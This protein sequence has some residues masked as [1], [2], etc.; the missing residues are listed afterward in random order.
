MLSIAA[1]AGSPCAT[2]ADGTRPTRKPIAKKGG[3]VGAL[4][5]KWDAGG[6]AAGNTGDYYDNRDGGHSRLNIAPYP[7]LQ[8]TNYGAAV[9]TRGWGAQRQ[10]LPHVTFGNSSTAS[11][12]TKGGSHTRRLYS[13]R[14]GLQLLHRQYV[15]NNVYVYPEHLDH[16]IGHNGCFRS[17]GF[18]DIFPTNTPYAIASQGSSGSDQPFVKAI[19][20]ALAAFRPEVKKRLVKAGLLMPTLQMIFRSTNKNLK[21]PG[22]YLTGRAHPTVFLGKNVDAL[23]MVKMA[24]AVRLNTIP[25]MMRL[26]VVEEDEPKHGRD[27]FDPGQTEKLADTPGVIARIVRGGAYRRRIVVSAEAT[28]D[29]NGR[30]LTYAWRVLR[31][32]ASRITITP[33]NDAKSVVEIVVAYHHWRPIA[34][35]SRLASNRVDIGAFVHNGAHYSAPGFITFFTLDHEER[36]YAADGRLLEIAYGAGSPV[37]L[38]KDWPK[39]LSLFHPNERAWAAAALRKQLLAAELA[40]VT[41]AA[42]DHKKAYAAV[43]ATGKPYRPVAKAYKESLTNETKAK[44]ALGAAKAAHRK[45]PTDATKLALTRAELALKA[46]QAERKKLAGRKSRIGKP[47]QVA[48]AAA[49]EILDRKEPGL[50]RSTRGLVEAA[51]DSLARDPLFLPRHR[52]NLGALFAKAPAPAKAAVT[53]ARK[54]YVQLGLITDSTDFAHEPRPLRKGDTPP[55]ERLSRYERSQLERLHKTVIVRLVFPEIVS[56]FYRTNYV[57]W[58]LSAPKSWRDLYDHDKRG[59]ITGWTRHE[60]DKQTEFNADGHIVLARDKLR[61]CTKARTVRYQRDPPKRDAKGRVRAGARRLL[62]WLPGNEILH[63]AYTDKADP[64]GRIVKREPAPGD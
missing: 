34:E 26:K 10:I 46:A 37:L 12:V 41:R 48:R 17:Q 9:R 47:H 3:S 52:A 39:A 57:D 25:P 55:V 11:Y 7:Q 43:V 45:A 59:E 50:K 49:N 32:D 63:Y 24:H 64:T 31:G 30:A 29:I 53:K 27:F 56:P 13:S 61:R 8:R 6:T 1:V 2:A 36:T 4:L 44:K 21:T 14:W 18:G 23:A 54:R 15:G 62:R 40:T 33:Q 19:P 22:D 38:I 20:Y 28:K 42:R 5:R 35:G 60:G 51:F 58:T 16:D